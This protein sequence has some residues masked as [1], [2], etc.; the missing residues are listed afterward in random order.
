MVIWL[1]GLSACGKS[2]LGRLVYELWKP[3]APNTVLVD[4]DE[5]RDIVRFNTGEDSYSQ[6]GR[7][8]IA[9]RYCDLCA[10]LDRQD[11]N[12]ICCTISAFEDLRARNRKT[13]SR[14]FEVFIT[15][16]LEVLSRR[17]ELDLYARAQRG[18]VH[19]V[20]GVDL[21]FAPPEMPDMVVDN[22]SDRDDLRPIADEILARARGFAGPSRR[23]TAAR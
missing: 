11:I 23:H 19:N 18:E 2:T 13:F 7:R 16:P 12:V 10:W 20:V 5:V 4:G 1:T 14:Y 9:E 21:A 22:S 17:H 3:D 15:A 6:S 8:A